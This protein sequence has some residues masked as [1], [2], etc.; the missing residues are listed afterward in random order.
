MKS[1]A[2]EM[3]EISIPQTEEETS[4]VPFNLN[5][6]DGL[7]PEQAKIVHQ[8]LKG[9]EHSGGVAYFTIHGKTLKEKET[10][11]RGGPHIDGNYE[12]KEM[13]F[14]R[15]GGN[16]WKVD[17]DGPGINTKFHKRQYLNEKGGIILAS[18]YSSCLG[19]I[20]DYKGTIKTGG[21]CSKIKLDKP[22]MLKANTVYYGNNHFIHESLPVDK[23]VQRTIVRITMPENHIYKRK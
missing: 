6:Y 15:G 5:T 13:S 14:G 16:G 21:D 20:G 22:F 17:Q 9:V 1:I 8:M 4:M 12:P 18:N 10:L 19:W 7:T 23:D 3:Y 11:R 2:K